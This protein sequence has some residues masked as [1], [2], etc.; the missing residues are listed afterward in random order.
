MACSRCLLLHINFNLIFLFPDSALQEL[1]GSMSSSNLDF[2]RKRGEKDISEASL[3]SP[4]V[5]QGRDFSKAESIRKRMAE[6]NK[7]LRAKSSIHLPDKQPTTPLAP[8]ITQDRSMSS[9]SRFD[10]SGMMV[11]F[12]PVLLLEMCCLVLS[13]MTLSTLPMKVGGSLILEIAHFPAGTVTVTVPIRQSPLSG[14]TY[15]LRVS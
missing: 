8:V 4:P 1:S 10:L 3:Q 7:N 11:Y 5:S 12:T 6:K 9:T 14:W 2:L 15:C 13:N